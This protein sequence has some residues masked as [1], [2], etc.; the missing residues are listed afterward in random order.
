MAKVKRRAEIKMHDLLMDRISDLLSAVAGID[1][2]EPG[3][4]IQH[5]LVVFRRQPA[6]FG[7]VDNAWVLF[8]CTVRCEWHP[9][10][11]VLKILN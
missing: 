2:P 5:L 7:S 4:S 8:E 3:G 11:G 6:T 1:A 10:R 9:E